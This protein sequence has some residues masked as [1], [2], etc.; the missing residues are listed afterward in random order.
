MISSGASRRGRS[1]HDLIRGA[2]KKIDIAFGAGCRQVFGHFSAHHQLG[3]PIERLF[4]LKIEF[5]DRKPAFP[6]D[7]QGGIRVFQSATRC[8]QLLKRKH[9][10]SCATANIDD[11]GRMQHLV[12]SAG[13]DWSASRCSRIDCI[14]I[15][16]PIIELLMCCELFH[17]PKQPF[18]WAARDGI[19]PQKRAQAPWKQS[20]ICRL[21]SMIDRHSTRSVSAK[22]RLRYP[23]PLRGCTP[24]IH[25]ENHAECE[26][27]VL[28]ATSGSA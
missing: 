9:H 15:V 28:L 17:S 26:K 24:A 12:H 3:A 16:I 18:P 25:G 13:H 4:L 19:G 1:D 27:H 21:Q 20:A 14:Q 6:T 11:G 2:A 5:F 10:L 23:P 7:H 22:T 8:P